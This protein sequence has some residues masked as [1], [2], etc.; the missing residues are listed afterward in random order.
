MATPRTAIGELDCPTAGC[1]LKASVYK[2]QARTDDPKKQRL[3]AKKPW[4][5]KC[6]KGHRCDDQD[7]IAQ[8]AKMWGDKPLA[9]AAKPP[10]TALPKPAAK[11]AQPPV[12]KP[13]AAPATKPK[14]WGFFE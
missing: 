12:S 2:V 5:C 10:V 13:P 14:G 9:T 4:Y 6:E 7:L 3:S 11:P 8:N 1:K